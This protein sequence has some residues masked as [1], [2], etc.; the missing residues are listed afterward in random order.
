MGETSV[1]GLSII[2][3]QNKQI[4]HLD[5]SIFGNAKE[6]AIQ[7]IKAG[8]LKYIQFHFKI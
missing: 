4:V 7:L 3:Y 2:I 1:E 8:T 5:Y 6:Q